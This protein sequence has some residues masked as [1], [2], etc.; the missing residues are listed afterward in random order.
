MLIKT[1]YVYIRDLKSP[2]YKKVI[3]FE[4]HGLKKDFIEKVIRIEKKQNY[5]LKKARKVMILII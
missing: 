5:N 3:R 1:L 2:I 4:I